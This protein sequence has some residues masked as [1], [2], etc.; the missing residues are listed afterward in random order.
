[1]HRRSQFVPTPLSA[2][3][4]DDMRKA[5]VADCEDL[6]S[7]RCAHVSAIAFICQKGEVSESLRSQFVQTPATSL[8]AAESEELV[9][10]TKLKQAE[11]QLPEAE[12]L[13]QTGAKNR[14]HL[15]TRI[16]KTTMRRASRRKHLPRSWMLCMRQWSPSVLGSGYRSRCCLHLFSASFKW[17]TRE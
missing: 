6:E 15:S 7:S 1:M 16:A 17:G 12:P 8:L 9:K 4:D 5:S 13:R 11:S 3:E 14:Q 10:K 2:I